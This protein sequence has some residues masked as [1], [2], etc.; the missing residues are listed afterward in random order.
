MPSTTP[1]LDDSHGHGPGFIEDVF[2]DGDDVTALIDRYRE[3]PI[4]DH[5]DSDDGFDPSG[6]FGYAN[7]SPSPSP[8]PLS[9]P[10]SPPPS[11][12]VLEHED[13]HI[14]VLTRDHTSILERERTYTPDDPAVVNSEGGGDTTDAD[15]ADDADADNTKGYYDDQF[16]GETFDLNSEFD[17]NRAID[18]EE[19]T[20]L[21]TPTPPPVDDEP[22]SS[23]EPKEEAAVAAPPP[24]IRSVTMQQQQQQ[25]QKEKNIATYMATRN[26][27]LA[28]KKEK[29]GDYSPGAATAAMD[30]AVDM[31]DDM[32]ERF[33]TPEPAAD[34][35][36]DDDADEIR[37]M[38]IRVCVRKRYGKSTSF[39]ECVL[40]VF[41]GIVRAI[42][43]PSPLPPP[44]PPP[45]QPSP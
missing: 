9:P 38:R 29:K 28:N 18:H 30:A 39:W 33:V 12:P 42:Y 7:V 6:E 8:S 37:N 5:R 31:D 21:E 2:S 45:P 41:L 26:R 23:P 11:P 35:D 25:G 24:M 19:S 40:G 15:D 44:P 1:D 14:S 20:V 34:D 32:E 3:S 17:I 43:P 16:E 4:G 27:A 36:D 10:P 22:E 13:T